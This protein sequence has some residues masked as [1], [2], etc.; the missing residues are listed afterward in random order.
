M[1]IHLF[2]PYRELV[3]A[4][5]ED[6]NGSINTS[7]LPRSAKRCRIPRLNR[8]TSMR[9]KNDRMD[10]LKSE[11]RPK[12]MTLS[13]QRDYPWQLEGRYGELGSM[14]SM[15][16]SVDDNSSVKS[17]GSFVSYSSFASQSQCTEASLSRPM[18]R[19]YYGKKYVLHC[20]R[21]LV[22]QEEYL[23]P[24]QRKDKEIRQLKSALMKQT[25]NC[26]EK[27]ME[28]ERLKD[29]LRR[30]QDA[31]AELQLGKHS[32]MNSSQESDNLDSLNVKNSSEISFES[33]ESDRSDIQTVTMNHDDS[34]VSNVMSMSPRNSS[35][36]DD[37]D[38]QHTKVQ[39]A[40]K[41]VLTDMSFSDFSPKN[42]RSDSN[43]SEYSRRGF[44]DR[45]FVDS[46]NTS[47][48]Q[49]EKLIAA[50]TPKIC[51][52]LEKFFTSYK[53]ELNQLRTQHKEHYQ[54]LKEGFNGRVD[55]LLQK[56]S[57]ANTRYLE[58]RP[59]F[60]K[61]QEKIQ[62]IESQLVEVRKDIETQE[63]YHNQMY[64]KMYRK[65]QE[66]ARLEQAD[67]A[68]DFS[69][70]LSKRISVPDLLRQL[71]Q[72]EME[73]DQTKQLYREAARGMGD[74]QAEYT[75]R[76]LK[77]AV[78]Y[79]LTKKDKEHLKAIQSILGFTDTERMAVA[80]AMKHR[81]L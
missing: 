62:S 14:N 30:L 67:E 25:K 4:D 36:F 13:S 61:T 74:R 64:L 12:S 27:N 60:D 11:G 71:H 69:P 26:E 48:T 33:N 19:S 18:S 32:L 20:D 70:H 21:H 43:E 29:D 45:S 22:K 38:G 17:F 58:L 72:L 46:P 15:P 50:A 6:T 53:E 47:S 80:K 7:T 2:P 35:E 8:S 9:V 55:D 79:F 52:E 73:L 39:T 65:G 76:F 41:A 16:F 49:E 59:L 78:F 81:R 68:L 3:M 10:S 66:T 31:I 75:L 28:I 54:D 37:L 1:N 24:T 57:E 77:D 63:D 23:T 51:Q 42:N 34:G 44:N 40:D 56:L 5:P